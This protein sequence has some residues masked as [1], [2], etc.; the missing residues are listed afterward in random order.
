[1]FQRKID[2][3]FKNPPNIFGTDDDILVASDKSDGKVQ[4]KTVWRVLQRCRQV[5]FKLNKDKCHFRCTS[6]PFFREIISQHGEKS[7]PQKIKALMELPPQ[8]K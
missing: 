2:E 5:N 3:I 1:M 6:I 8:P 4:D 7:D